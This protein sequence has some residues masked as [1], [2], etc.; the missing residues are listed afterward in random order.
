[1]KGD[2]PWPSDAP[3]DPSDCGFPGS[4]VRVG[5][6]FL[7]GGHRSSR[8]VGKA[9]GGGEA[10]GCAPVSPPFSSAS[11]PPFQNRGGWGK[12]VG[13]NL[14]LPALASQKFPSGGAPGVMDTATWT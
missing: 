5:D 13:I 2:L 8:M 6:G 14:L 9:R 3:R 4:L 10:W 11:H 12:N 7:L 1:M